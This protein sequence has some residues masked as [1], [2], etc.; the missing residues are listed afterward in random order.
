MKKTITLLLIAVSLNANCQ[1]L[2]ANF[3]TSITKSKESIASTVNPILNIEYSHKLNKTVELTASVGTY[4]YGLVYQTTD[5]LG[6][7]DK[8]ITFTQNFI[9]TTIG[10]SFFLSQKS[11]R[12][13]VFGNLGAAFL[14]STSFF[15]DKRHFIY[16]LGAGIE[17]K[18]NKFNYS[19]KSSYLSDIENKITGATIQLGLAV[20]IK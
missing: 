11:L 2:K 10:T 6:N 20:N 4:K 19:I 5:R 7:P 3:C 13:F 18:K 14:T 12:P 15:V 17:Y 1:T 9:T 8:N 16:N